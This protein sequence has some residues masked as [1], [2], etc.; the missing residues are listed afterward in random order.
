MEYDFPIGEG[1]ADDK[2]K[3]ILDIFLKH[4]KEVTVGG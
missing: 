1:M 4:V 3:P 2:V